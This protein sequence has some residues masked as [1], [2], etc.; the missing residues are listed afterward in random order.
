MLYLLA[1]HDSPH[2]SQ[3]HGFHNIVV[4]FILKVQKS[5][6]FWSWC[7]EHQTS[8]EEERSRERGRRAWCPLWAVPEV[9]KSWSCGVG[10]QE[11]TDKEAAGGGPLRAKTGLVL[12]PQR[13]GL[14][15]NPLAH[16]LSCHMSS[17]K[18][19][20]LPENQN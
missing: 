9:L 16:L 5:L 7:W 4:T 11:V 17:V 12:A 10:V 18:S 14:I 3:H 19:L 13:A 15:L 6:L 20:F 8:I 2:C 1:C